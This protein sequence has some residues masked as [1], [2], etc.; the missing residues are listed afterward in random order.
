MNKKQLDILEKAFDAEIGAA[1]SGGFPIIQNRCKTT[2]QLL[3]DGY[4]EKKT[5][6]HGGGPFACEI[7]GYQ[8]SDLGRM[9]YCTS[10]RC[11]DAPE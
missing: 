1:L 6:I 9:A 7:K 3:A 5:I 4:L 8:I 10:D 11:K 2:M